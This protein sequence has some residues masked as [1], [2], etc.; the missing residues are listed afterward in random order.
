MGLGMKRVPGLKMMKEKEKDGWE[1]VKKNVI[2]EDVKKKKKVEGKRRLWMMMKKKRKM[3][4]VEVSLQKKKVKF[5]KDV[6]KSW[7]PIKMDIK[8]EVMGEV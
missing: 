2:K 5:L 1:G 6:V 4:K 7:N 8:M 3:R